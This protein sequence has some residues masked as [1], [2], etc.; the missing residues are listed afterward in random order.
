MSVDEGIK[1]IQNFTSARDYTYPNDLVLV[2]NLTASVLDRLE[3]R[4]SK[5]FSEVCVYFLVF[6]WIIF[7]YQQQFG[8]T[9]SDLLEGDAVNAISN[10]SETSQVRS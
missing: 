7:S 3:G 1:L 9:M 4:A 2:K 10:S 6:D 8:L 5:E